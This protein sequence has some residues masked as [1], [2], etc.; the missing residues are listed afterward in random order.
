MKRSFFFRRILFPLL[1][2]VLAA[3]AGS[4]SAGEQLPGRKSM[5][6]SERT[7]AGDWYGTWFYKSRDQRIVLW[8]R[9]GEHNLP[10][11]R[12]HYQ[13]L[14]SPEAFVTDWSGVAEYS[15]RGHEAVFRLESK[16][17]GEN[18]I[19]GTL[20]W[21]LQFTR[22]GRTREADVEIYRGRDGR[23]LV[24]HF[25]KQKLTIKRK[26]KTAVDETSGAWTFLKASRRIVRWE[27]IP[28]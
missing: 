10:E 13:S 6:I 11:Y 8:F 18:L 16:S 26:G 14:G 1:V 4:I 28:F 7:D 25:L 22:S 19:Q 23:A 17:R 3:G 27:E 12:L 15:V 9:R 20:F 2:L 24:M 21:D 5:Q